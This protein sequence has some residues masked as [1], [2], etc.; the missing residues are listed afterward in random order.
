M[1]PN[2]QPRFQFSYPKSCRQSLGCF[3]PAITPIGSTVA[4]CTSLDSMSPFA[5]ARLPEDFFPGP[6]VTHM[7]ECRPLSRRMRDVGVLGSF[8]SE[9][10]GRAKL[11]TRN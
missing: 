2:L 8:R 1:G 6:C 11:S 5:L 7:S 9:I 4:C 10:D 3:R